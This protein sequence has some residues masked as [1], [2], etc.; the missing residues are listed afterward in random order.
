MD[1]DAFEIVDVG[2]G[3]VSVDGRTDSLSIRIRGSGDV[4]AA[5]L[6]SND[7]A[8]R[9]F[10]SGDASVFASDS[11]DVTITGSGNVDYHGD[12]AKFSENVSGSGRI[13][14]R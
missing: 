6:R 13:R 12:P 10:G 3:S 11:L 8:I 4:N 5:D 7:V 14:S 9:L 2:S 1:E